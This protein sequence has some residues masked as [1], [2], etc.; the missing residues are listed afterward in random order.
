MILSANN[1]LY[2]LVK[3][4]L[5]TLA[6]LFALVSCSNGGEEGEDAV[7][8]PAVAETAAPKRRQQPPRLCA[9]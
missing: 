4:S 8:I 5:L 3:A 6:L 1:C 9:W 2:N 7:S